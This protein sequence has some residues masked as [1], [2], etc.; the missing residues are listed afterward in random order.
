MG[1]RW[2]TQRLMMARVS[3]CLPASSHNRLTGAYFGAFAS[4]GGGTAFGP[5]LTQFP[6]LPDGAP[7]GA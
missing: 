1:R 2:F 3:E 7:L 4:Y 5:S 6:A